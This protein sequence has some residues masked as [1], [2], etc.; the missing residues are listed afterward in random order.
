MKNFT[1]VIFAI[2]LT[3]AFFTAKGDVNYLSLK[4]DSGV[5]TEGTAFSINVLTNDRFD[6]PLYPDNIILG[7]AQGQ[8]VISQYGTWTSGI[9]LNTATGVV[10]VAATVPVGV[11]KVKYNVKIN[12][13]PYEQQADVTIIVKADNVKEAGETLEISKIIR[14]VANDCNKMEVTLIAEGVKV[15]KPIETVLVL[16]K[17]ISMNNT[18]SGDPDTPLHYL[19]QAAVEF[20][21]KMFDP[22]NN[23]S[24]NNKIA[25]VKYGLKGKKLLDLVDSS[26][27]QDIIDE[28]NAI[29]A[30]GYTNISD[31]I[32]K[33]AK[34]LQ[35]TSTQ[36]NTHRNIVVFTD[37]VATARGYIPAITCSDTSPTA[38]NDCTQAAMT[39]GQAAHNIG[40]KKVSVYSVLLYGSFKH[41]PLTVQIARETMDA[42]QNTGGVYESETATDLSDLYNDIFESMKVAAKDIT[43]TDDADYDILSNNV[44]FSDNPIAAPVIVT[45]KNIKWDLE[46]ILLGQT[47]KFSYIMEVPYP[48]GCGNHTDN[49]SSK[50][51]YETYNSSTGVCG[52][53]TF[54]FPNVDYCVPCTDQTIVSL[55][56]DGNK[57]K[58]KGSITETHNC[59]G[60][61]V[62]FQW[63]FYK[64]SSTTP[65]ETSAEFSLATQSDKL[66]GEI[67]LPNPGTTQTVK[68]VLRVRIEMPNS[69]CREQ[70]VEKVASVLDPVEVNIDKNAV[71]ALDENGKRIFNTW[72]LTLEVKTGEGVIFE[73]VPTDVVLVMDVSSSMN[74]NN[75]L[76]KAK[77]AAR[78]F[79]DQMLPDGTATENMRIALVSYN[80]QV[81]I[82]QSFTNDPA[83]LKNKINGLTTTSGTFTQGG[84]HE[85]RM[86]LQSSTALNKHIVLLTDGVARE[87]YPIQYPGTY[88]FKEKNTGNELIDLVIDKAISHPGSYVSPSG[89]PVPKNS[90][91]IA[92]DNLQEDKYDYSGFLETGVLLYEPALGHHPTH[93]YFPCNAAINEARFAKKKQITV[94]TVALDLTMEVGKLTV[95]K[96]A[97]NGCFYESTPDELNNVFQTIANDLTPVLTA[98]VIEDVIAPGFVLQDIETSAPVAEG[99]ILDNVTVSQGSVTYDA[100]T[101]KLTWDLGSAKPKQTLTLTYRLHLED[102]SAAQVNNTSTQGP[103]IGGF[104]TNSWA[105]FNYNDSNN[106]PQEE[107][108]PRPTVKPMLDSDGDGVPDMYDLDDDNDGILDVNECGTLLNSFSD[109]GFE[110]DPDTD[111]TGSSSYTTETG[112]NGKKYRV[113]LNEALPNGEKDHFKIN[114]SVDWTNGQYILN[115]YP[116]S[117]DYWPAIRPSS[118]G[119]AFIIFSRGGEEV[120][121]RV[122]NPQ[123]DEIYELEFELG[124]LPAYGQGVPS[125][126]G[127]HF[128]DNR[129]NPDFKLSVTGAT[130]VSEP[131][132]ATYSMADYPATVTKNSAPLDPKWQVYKYVVKATGGTPVVLS[133]KTTSGECVVTLDSFF[134][135]KGSLTGCDEDGDGI[136]NHLD[137]DSDNDGCLDAIEGGTNDSSD[138]ITD[139]DLVPAGGTVT[140]GAGSTGE[141]KNLCGGTDCVYDNGVPKK[142]DEN[143][144]QAVGGSQNEL[145]YQITQ[146]PVNTTVCEKGT[147]EFTAKATSTPAKDLNYQWQVST[148]G[149]ANWVD[150]TDVS[151]TATTAGIDGASGTGVTASGNEA[152]LTLSNV[153]LNMNDNQYRVI[154]SH[155]DNICGTESTE[156]VLKVQPRPAF[157]A[158]GTNAN[159]NDGD[160]KIEVTITSNPDDYEFWLLPVPGTD[161]IKLKKVTGV[162]TYRID[163][164]GTETNSLT[165][166]EVTANNKITILVKASGT[167]RVIM[168]NK[169][170]EN[171]ECECTD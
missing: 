40:G 89:A 85:A 94:H 111:F 74:D 116:Q 131:T 130:V 162:N 16:D 109:A 141:N 9:T 135:K 136:P 75:R 167:Y 95:E 139:A 24:G 156:A 137:L 98:G 34:I 159:C 105:K 140:V 91:K 71:P 62:F 107:Y 148:D 128:G 125:G 38:H 13:L 100:T 79:V 115:S 154:Y 117:H 101:K 92:K 80:K 54:N 146:Q 2:I 60:C 14:P 10:N 127:L 39:S 30:G 82:Q 56:R 133:F 163:N 83:L 112:I 5:G 44:N 21:E 32:D 29:T 55:A 46:K 119:G 123:A 145:E 58:Y 42:I 23:P 11:Y 86:L 4:P 12:A 134:V 1:K 155:N 8:A 67:D 142:V 50:I 52:L 31:G 73:Q 53:E 160:S 27:K 6:H 84:L 76:T 48:A 20:V 7:T 165:K 25:L 147:A 138:P 104:D 169:N 37:G 168:K 64:D 118:N 170:A 114:N 151:A 166:T 41:K 110:Y 45:G 164:T 149:G 88:Y 120:Q 33:A 70:S 126:V 81:Q 36:C 35:T 106:T 18:I 22:V 153:T 113:W 129:Y 72:D 97:S 19:K 158:T 26:Q 99:D 78:A 87:Q 43:I 68:A 49:S 15:D 144:G 59:T 132:I 96:I 77:E 161:K 3:I 69:G 124:T 152:R 102:I 47:V 150:L 65:F 61:E 63:D 51:T 57:V 122:E 157:T 103:D 90:S 171:C 28:I 93:Y 121:Y 17:S 108:F 143:E 66:E